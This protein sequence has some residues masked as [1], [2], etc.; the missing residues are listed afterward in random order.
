MKKRQVQFKYEKRKLR[1]L[2]MDGTFKI[3]PDLRKPDS[4]HLP[5][6]KKELPILEWIKG[7]EKLKLTKGML[8]SIYTEWKKKLDREDMNKDLYFFSHQI[9]KDM[10]KKK[11]KSEIRFGIIKKYF[12]SIL[13][14]ITKF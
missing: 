2:Q 14:P 6:K 13:N 10:S 1:V 11:Q 4:Y 12:K 8:D 9:K 7:R 5:F 3:I